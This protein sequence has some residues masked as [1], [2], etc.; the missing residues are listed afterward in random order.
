MKIVD[1]LYID[2]YG[3]LKPRVDKPPYEMLR[4]SYVYCRDCDCYSLKN[5]QVIKRHLNN[6]KH[7]LNVFLTEWLEYQ[8]DKPRVF[9]VVDDWDDET[10]KKVMRV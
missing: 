8:N 5:S 2:T 1:R 4:D 6:N 9:W 7:K 3:N 10:P